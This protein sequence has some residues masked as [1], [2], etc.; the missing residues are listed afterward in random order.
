MI[1]A[2]ISCDKTSQE[3][4]HKKGGREGKKSVH[5]IVFG[6]WFVIEMAWRPLVARIGSKK[7]IR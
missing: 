7:D 6:P 1:G 4:E 3:T 5:I 2:A